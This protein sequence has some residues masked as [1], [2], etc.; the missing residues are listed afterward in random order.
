MAD[1]KEKKSTN[2]EKGFFQGVN[3]EFK[4]I[5]WPTKDDLVKQSIFRC[6]GRCDFSH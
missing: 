4:K 1:K 5:V 2:E 6:I 3:K